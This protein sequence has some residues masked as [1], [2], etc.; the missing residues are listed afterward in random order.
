MKKQYITL[1]MVIIGICTAESLEQQEE[2]I[3]LPKNKKKYVSE[4]Q[5]IELAGEVVVDTHKNIERFPA[6]QIPLAHLQQL[7]ITVQQ[8]CLMTLN[9]YVDGQKD[10]FLKQV[11]K[12]QRTDC[13]EKLLK[14]KYKVEA[15]TKK[16]QKMQQHIEFMHKELQQQFQELLNFLEVK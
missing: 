3:T 16:M 1:L 5:Y 2:L 13:Y 4:Q 11:N 9:D 15:Y 6:L 7:I 12:V 8:Q 14:C 10:C